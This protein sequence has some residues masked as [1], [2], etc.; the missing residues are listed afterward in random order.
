MAPGMLRNNY[1]PTS[2]HPADGQGVVSSAKINVTREGN[3][4]HYRAAI[5]WSELPLVKPLAMA[6][7]DIGFSFVGMNDNRSAVSW[8]NQSRSVSK[9]G[10]EVVHPTFSAGWSPDTQWGFVTLKT[11]SPLEIPS[12]RIHNS[13]G[14]D[15]GYN[16]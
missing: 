3:V 8:S 15:S 2:P 16:E 9:Q 4:Y 7:H 11:L 6:G 14:R 12:T 5:P 1:S 10:Q 13:S